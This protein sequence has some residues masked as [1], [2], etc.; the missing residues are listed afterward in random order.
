MNDSNQQYDVMIVGAGMVGATM[1]CALAQLP[2][3]IALIEAHQPQTDWDADSYVVERVIEGQF[4]E[5]LI[6]AVIDLGQQVGIVPEESA[7]ENSAS[8][9]WVGIE[10]DPDNNQLTGVT[11]SL[12]NGVV[13]GY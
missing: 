1:A 6:D 13:L 4:D 12:T 5:S 8:G 2:L 10:I 11:S 7:L 9:L 3:R